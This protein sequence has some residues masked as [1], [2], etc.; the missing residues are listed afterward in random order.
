DRARL[1]K[2]AHKIGEVAAWR[3]TFIG[4]AVDC[5]GALVVD[6]A[7]M[8]GM[9]QPPHNVAAHPAEADHPELHVISP[10]FTP[11]PRC[12]CHPTISNSMRRVSPI[13]FEASR[14]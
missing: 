13:R 4:Q 8:P 3:R 5:V 10:E 11:R 14:I 2:L 6:D 9:H 1:L 12:T 7:T